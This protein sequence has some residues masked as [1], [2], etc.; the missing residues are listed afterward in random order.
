MFISRA[1]P[2]PEQRYAQ[3]EK[4]ALA[5]TWACE[6][7]ADYLVG[8]TFHIETDHKPLFP[9]LGS[10]NLDE[11]PLRIQRLTMQLLQFHFTISYVP[12]TNLVTADTLSR[13]PLQSTSCHEK[14]EIDLYVD[15]VLLQLPASEEI[16]A[17]QQE[18]L[19]CRKLT[20]YCK[21]KDS[22]TSTSCLYWSSKGEI[23]QVQGL[24]LKGATLIIPSGMR[25]KILEQIHEGYQGIAKCRRQVKDSV[26]SP[27][28]S[29]QV[30]DMVTSCRKCIDYRKLN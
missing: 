6:R 11:M 17:K 25:L 24:L 5:T 8:K 26:W 27:G 2:N 21:K 18:Y 29:K 10:K 20:E 22:P 28:L 23:S 7:L 9:L 3:I 4:E 15:S 30:E 19:V 14:E 1:L 16:S 12:S 13:T